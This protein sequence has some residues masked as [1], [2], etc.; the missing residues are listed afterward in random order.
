M[1]KSDDARVAPPPGD[2]RPDPAA[3]DEQDPSASASGLSLPT[4]NQ[5]SRGD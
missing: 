1:A 5:R 2:A 3:V 4:D